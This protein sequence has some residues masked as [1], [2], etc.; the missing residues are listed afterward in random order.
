MECAEVGVGGW[1]WG[2]GRGQTA[3]PEEG[4]GVWGWMDVCVCVWGVCVKTLGVR[5]ARQSVLRAGK[6]QQDVARWCSS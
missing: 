4:R 1:G 2:G 6:L 3:P 5:A